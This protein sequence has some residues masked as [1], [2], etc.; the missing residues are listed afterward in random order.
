M[1]HTGVFGSTGVPRAMGTWGKSGGSAAHLERLFVEEDVAP[2]HGDDLEVVQFVVGSL[3]AVHR[4][5][6]ELALRLQ[7]RAR[8]YEH[9]ASGARVRGQEL[10]LGR[11]LRGALVA[12]APADNLRSEVHAGVGHR[13]GAWGHCAY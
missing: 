8:A 9:M 7:Q 6:E 1:A 2:A 4:P 11:G 12:A 5:P 10:I 3:P 13:S